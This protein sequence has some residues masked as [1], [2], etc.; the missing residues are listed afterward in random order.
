MWEC[1]Y[2]NEPIDKKLLLIGFVKR[3]WI[4]ILGIFLGALL[5]GGTYFLKNSVFA[6]EKLYCAQGDTYVEYIPEEGYGISTVFLNGDVWKALVSSD[7]FVADMEAQLAEK[8][9]TVSK[10]LIASS[11]DAALEKDTRIVTTRVTTNDPALSVEIGAALQNAVVHYGEDYKD[12]EKAYI[13]TG[14]DTAELVITDA[15]TGRLLI[16]GAVLGGMIS[17]AGI[18]LYLLL[19]DSVYVPEQF[20]HRYQIPVLGI[21]QTKELSE[22]LAYTL[23]DCQNVKLMGAEPDIPVMELSKELSEKLSGENSGKFSLGILK[24]VSC[25]EENPK[26]AEEL[27]AADGV[28]LVV[29]SGRRDGKRIEKILRFL[30]TQDCKVKGALLWNADKGLLRLYYGFRKR[31]KQV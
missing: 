22:N 25:T 10:E 18:F 23:R 13:L 6:A 24:P 28:L 4:F 26:E 17:L 9:I 1:N 16:L 27:R 31:R 14:A 15:W 30:D 12:I 5:L 2:A 3:I 20:E 7:A 19:D 29:E 11:V 21:W 8:G